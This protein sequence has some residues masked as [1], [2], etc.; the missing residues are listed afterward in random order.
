MTGVGLEHLHGLYAGGDDPWAFRTSGY[1][2]QKF[3]QTRKALSRTHYQSAFELGCGNGQLAY[4][5]ADIC[6]RYAGMDAVE[7]A[8]EAARHAVPTASFTQGYYPCPLPDDDF[9]LLIFS[10]ILY[11]LDK[12]SLGTLAVTVADKWPDAELICVSYFGQSGNDLQGSDAFAI[13]AHALSGTHEFDLVWQTE[14]Y[15]IDCGLPRA[16]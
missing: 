8:L 14:G 3:A 2:R 9:D 7:K 13:F 5:L 10:E 16:G 4:H 11:F 15:R 6:A 12:D 1:E